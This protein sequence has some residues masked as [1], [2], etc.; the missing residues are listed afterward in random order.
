MSLTLGSESGRLSSNGLFAYGY[1]GVIGMS[2]SM[3]DGF[4]DPLCTGV[5]LQES[6]DVRLF[7]QTSLL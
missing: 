7:I 2:R 6:F 5:E 4:N 3:L 1:G